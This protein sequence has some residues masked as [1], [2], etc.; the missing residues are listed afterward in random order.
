MSNKVEFKN[1]GKSFNGQPAVSNVNFLINDGQ[2]VTLLGPSGCGKTTTLRMVAGL[3]LPS[4]GSIF[5]GDD[6]VTRVSAAQRSVGMVFQSYALFPHMTVMDNVCYGLLANKVKKELAVILATEALDKV[7][8]KQ[9]VAR[10]PSELSGGQQQRVAIAR[11]LVTQ[12]KVLLF[13]EP[14]SN[15]DAK[16]RRKVRQDIRDLQRDIG[17]TSVYVTHDQEEALAISDEIIVMEQG[18]I[19]QIGTPKALYNSPNSRFV[20]DFIGDTNIV[21][22]EALKLNDNG[23][24]KLTLE[25]AEFEHSKRL[26]AKESYCL[27]IRPSAIRLFTANVGNSI[28]ATVLSSSYLGGHKEYN[29]CTDAGQEL[30]VVDHSFDDQLSAGAVVYATINGFGASVVDE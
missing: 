6:D 4:E 12:P 23:T 30:F 14:L 1:V 21:T 20:A 3:E 17:V 9:L 26:V 10:H 2:L 29:L 24:T 11:S 13:D 22:C 27:S 18:R 8:M 19:K 16:L 15:L 28:K 5:I 7:G 25:G